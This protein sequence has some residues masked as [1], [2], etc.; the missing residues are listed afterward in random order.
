MSVHETSPAAAAKPA[1]HIVLSTKLHD[2]QRR[3]LARIKRTIR[4]KTGGGVHE[5]KVEMNSDTLRLRG[6]CSSFY[7]K[8][9]AQHAAMEYLVGETLI[10]EIEVDVIPR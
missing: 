9:K 6:H 5:L 1:D 4:R 2:E 8:Q 10:N 7:C 3:R